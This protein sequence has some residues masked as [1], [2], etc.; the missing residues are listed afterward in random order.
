MKLKNQ[1]GFV[2]IA[3]FKKKKKKKR[4]N[5]ILAMGSLH[6]IMILEGRGAE[7]TGHFRFLAKERHKT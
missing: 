7:I 1:F 3:L 4:G 2:S 6:R 5:Q